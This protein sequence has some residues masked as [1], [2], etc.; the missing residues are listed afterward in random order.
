[1]SSRRKT[2]AVCAFNLMCESNDYSAG[3]TDFAP[4]VLAACTAIHNN[5][6]TQ[7]GQRVQLFYEET[8]PSFG[9]GTFRQMFKHFLL[10]G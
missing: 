5:N 7:I 10:K 6:E 9:D 4:I 8:I 2:I 3:I 1:M